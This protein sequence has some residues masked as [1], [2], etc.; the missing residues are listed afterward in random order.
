TPE[1]MAGLLG[2]FAQAGLVNLV[3]GCCGTTPQ[4]IEAIVEAVAGCQP[5]R[6]RAAADTC[7][8][9][10]LEAADLNTGVLVNVGE[11]TNVTGSARFAKLILNEDFDAAIKVAR[12]QVDNGAQ[13]LDINMDEGMLD[14]AAAMARYLNLLAAEPDISRIP[15]MIDSSKWSVIEAGLRCVQGKCIVNSI[16]LKAGE[17]EFLQ[18]ARLV[19]RYGAAVVVMAFDEEGQAD[20]LERRVAVCE[21]AYRLLTEQVN[22]PAHDIIFDANI[23]AVATGIEAHNDYGR[24][25]IE[26]VRRIKTSLPS[27]LTSGG[28][29]NLSFSFRGNNPLREAMHAVFLFHAVKAGLDMA[30]INAGR[31]PV[32]QDIDEEV[33]LRIEDV[34]FNRRTDAGDRLLEIASSVHGQAEARTQ[35][36]SW[37]D[38][39]IDE[40]I[41]HALIHG[42][43]EFVVQDAEEARLL[44]ARP[45]DVIEG[46]LMTGMNTVGDLFGD[47]KMFLPQVVKSA[48][49]MKK[50]VAHLEPYMEDED[51]APRS[52]G[53][54]VIATAKGDVHD[55]GKNIV[56]VVLRCNN[57]EVVDLG[58]MVPC[59]TLLA[60]AK[61]EGADIVGVSGLITPSL[62]EMSHVA[63]EMQRAGLDIPLLIGGATTSH[64]HT[65]VKIAPHYEAATV[66]VPNASRAVGVVSK[67]LG[68]EGAA[69]KSAIADDYA[70]V[71]VKRE[72]ANRRAKRVPLRVA[73]ANRFQTEWADYSPPQPNHPG[74][75]EFRE[76]DLANLVDY[77]DWTPFFRT[78]ELAGTYPRL[79]DDTVIGEAARALFDDARSMLTRIVD[80]KWLTAHAV[81]GIWPAASVGDDIEVFADPARQTVLATIPTLRQQ[82]VRD[83][84]RANLALADFVAPKDSAQ[85]DFIGG[86]AVSTGFGTQRWAAEF[87]AK[88]DD[89]NAIMVRALSDR[90]AEALAER[91]HEEVRTRLWGY[92]NEDDLDQDDLRRE[93][94]QGIRPAPGY[95]AC[96]DHSLKP[97]LF[98]LLDAENRIGITLTEQFAMSP[99]ASVSGYYFSH[100]ESCYFG[101]SRVERDQVED[102]ARR[103]RVSVEVAERWLTPV[104]GYEPSPALV[105]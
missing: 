31:L 27:V 90:L 99:A 89:Y 58:V 77:I 1:H 70:A 49:V 33:R 53:K 36:L 2:E 88:H 64:V 7:R 78:W 92:A 29:S 104:L 13:V 39:T 46:P 26:A 5:R 11:R 62:D 85:P 73:R 45:L 47:G 84:K 28:V 102:Y 67:L 91:M 44:A 69:Y 37:R 105:A 20:T 10:G 18:Q 81:V 6:R 34:L 25:F 42:I 100:P 68:E 15:V 57:Y 79:L 30:I 9:S 24:S 76:Y 4:H 82:L 38:G 19:R 41:E 32:Y 101:V 54:I 8:L 74:V 21:R 97:Q 72:G 51:G 55:I 23:F 16:S 66:Y 52:H 22:F 98:N 80:E 61:E 103:R 40:R 65:A 3:G 83:G 14:S 93:R 94:Y 59:A 56:G 12:D 86:F 48:R 96:P 75:H 71:R 60:R 95:P 17:E 35:D 50:A 87:E 63:A 43:D